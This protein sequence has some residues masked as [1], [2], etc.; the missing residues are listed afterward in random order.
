MKKLTLLISLVLLPLFSIF[1]QV[2]TIKRIEFE[3]KEG[4]DFHDLANLV[5]MAY[6]STRKVQIKKEKQESGK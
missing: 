3:L 1:G 4:F 2:E 5:I 6:Y